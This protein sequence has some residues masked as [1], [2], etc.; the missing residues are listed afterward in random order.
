MRTPD[1]KA[2]SP[3]AFKQALADILAGCKRNKVAAGI[4]TFSAEDARMRIDEGWQFI[5]VG[6]ELK[7]M[8]DGAKKVVDAL[9][10]GKG[11]GDLAKY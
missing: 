2:P 10:L 6:S 1:G 3:E 7:L 8:I 9:G 4:H 5:A 11:A